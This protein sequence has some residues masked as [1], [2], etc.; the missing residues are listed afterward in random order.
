MPIHFAAENGQLEF[1]QLLVEHGSET[2]GEGDDHELEVIGW[3]TCFTQRRIATSPTTSSP[4]V[5]ARRSSP[6]T[7][8]GDVDAIRAIVAARP[9]DLDRPMDETNHRRRPLHLAIVKKRPDSLDTLLE[10]GADTER[11]RRGGA[12]AARSGSDERRDAAWW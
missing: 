11:R 7:A 3:A 4:T 2:I 12:H 9:D 10:L 8:L 1:V 6:P 5:L